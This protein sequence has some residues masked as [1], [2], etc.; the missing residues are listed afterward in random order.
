MA[1]SRPAD[2][3]LRPSQGSRGPGRR[4][5]EQG[6]GRTRA[7]RQERHKEISQDF[8]AD[9]LSKTVEDH[10]GKLS[11]W[12]TRLQRSWDEHIA[13]IRQ[14][15]DERRS[16]HNLEA[17]Q[18]EADSAEEDASFAVF[19]R[20]RRSMRLGPRCSPPVWRG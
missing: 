4:R 11:A 1:L 8:Q 7:G 20:T 3:T 2:Q 15:I 14:N 19:T 6:Q 12:W 13:E 10:K 9:R 18:R 5:A 16:S 17:A